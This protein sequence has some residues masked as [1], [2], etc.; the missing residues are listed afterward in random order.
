ML[1]NLRP[2]RLSRRPEPFDSDGFLYELK[3]DGFRALAHLEDGKGELVSRNGN[4]FHGFAELATWIAEHLKVESAVLDAEIAC[5]DREGRPIFTD[6]LFR[7]S[8]CILVAF[9]LLYLNRNDLRTLPLMTKATTPKAH[10]SET[11]TDPVPR[12]HRERG[13]GDYSRRL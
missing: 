9:D 10:S 6:L 12:P 5:V 4:T 8:Q 11:F 1:R 2:I 7:R 3:I 13:V